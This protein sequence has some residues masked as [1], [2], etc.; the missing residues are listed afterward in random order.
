M[1]ES[2]PHFVELGWS[3]AK[4]GVQVRTDGSVDL[5]QDGPAVVVIKSMIPRPPPRLT[6]PEAPA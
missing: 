4:R 3:E 6:D 5:P 1:A 2:V